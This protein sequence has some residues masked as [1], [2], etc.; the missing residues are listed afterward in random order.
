MDPEHEEMKEKMAMIQKPRKSEYV[1]NQVKK[2]KVVSRLQSDYNAANNVGIPNSNS[3]A[4]STNNFNP[5]ISRQT[6]YRGDSFGEEGSKYTC[7]TLDSPVKLPMSAQSKKMSDVSSKSGGGGL[8]PAIRFGS[9]KKLKEVTQKRKRIESYSEEVK[10]LEI[11]EEDN[12]RN[13]KSVIKEEQE[14]GN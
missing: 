9:K 10:G 1:G 4:S 8:G 7:M 12:K 6:S 5:V 14:A 3:R 13:M 11:I 2:P